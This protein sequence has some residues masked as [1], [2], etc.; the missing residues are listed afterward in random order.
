VSRKADVLASWGG[1][2]VQTGFG[3]MK[4]HGSVRVV[5]ISAG[6]VSSTARTGIVRIIPLHL[7]DSMKIISAILV[8]LALTLSPALLAQTYTAWNVSTVGIGNG[9]TTNNHGIRNDFR[10]VM[11]ILVTHLSLSDS[12]SDVTDRQ[13]KT[14]FPISPMTR[15]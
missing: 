14:D 9:E 4:A 12:G 13:L 10:A 7:F 3:K 2:G 8:A 5:R 15:S 11:P 6:Q 1:L